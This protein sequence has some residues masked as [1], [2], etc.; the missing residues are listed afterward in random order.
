MAGEVKGKVYEAITKVA[1][2]AAINGN[3]KGWKVLWHEQPDWISI[4][5]D[6]AIGADKNSIE[7]LIM[8][9]HSLSEKLSEKKFWRNFGE[10]FQWK[11][12]GAQAVKVLGV[13]FDAAIK[14]GL[15]AVEESV[16]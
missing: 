16:I 10:V 1:L 13:L 3:R 4:E 11:V 15:R 2:E 9:T 5:A 6:L 14:P 7:A 8:V 12:H